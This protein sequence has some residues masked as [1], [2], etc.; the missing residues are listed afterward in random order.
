MF[1]LEPI[2]DRDL[3]TVT[4]RGRLEQCRLIRTH[5]D[6]AIYGGAG[7][8]RGPQDR[9]FGEGGRAF[10]PPLLE[11]SA[12]RIASPDGAHKLQTTNYW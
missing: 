12:R 3:E 11:R 1:L 6:R 4:L 2:R 7:S 5:Y 8:V 9:Q 10:H